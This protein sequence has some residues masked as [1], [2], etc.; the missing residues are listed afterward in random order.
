[1]LDVLITISQDT[2]V[3]WVDQAIVSVN[4]AAEQADYPVQLFLIPGVPGH[5]G[6]AMQA[7][8]AYGHAPYIAWVDDDDFVEPHAFS[9]LASS[10]A[11]NPK[12]IVA[13]E[14]HLLTNGHTVPVNLRHHLSA[15]RR[16]VVT[17][18]DLSLYPALPN[19]ALYKAADD[20][21]EDILAWVYTR[22]IRRSG[23]HYLRASLSP[24]ERE[25]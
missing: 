4:I 23:G 15:F 25:L 2:P 18:V 8:A 9:V 17:S 6:K 22:R 11:R 20:H 14:K 21:V 24:I 10:F 3:E 12:R 7:G 16:D 5:I 13:R 19:V 1:M